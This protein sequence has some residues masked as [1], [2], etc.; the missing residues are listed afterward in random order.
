MDKA[1][2]KSGDLVRLKSSGPL[3]TVDHKIDHKSP[4]GE[5]YVCCWFDSTSKYCSAIFSVDTL[6]PDNNATSTD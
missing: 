4:A 6:T 2:F 5:A 3:M 1:V